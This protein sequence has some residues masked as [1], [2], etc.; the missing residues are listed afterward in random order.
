MWAPF[1]AGG[2][3]GQNEKTSE[4][5]PPKPDIH[6]RLKHWLRRYRFV[7]TEH[8]RV[9]LDAHHDV[10]VDVARNGLADFQR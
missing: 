2:A 8:R 9:G 6:P 1:E 5:K 4:K 7:R 3:L 10:L